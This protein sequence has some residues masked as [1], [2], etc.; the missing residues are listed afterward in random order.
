MSDRSYAWKLQSLRVILPMIFA[1]LTLIFQGLLI[2]YWTG[3]A[4][5]RIKYEAE[6]VAKAMA[7]FQSYT[8]ADVLTPRE[9]HVAFNN[10][11]K[12]MD[13]A[14]LP[15]NPA[16]GKPFIEGI[17]LD[18]DPE[19]VGG[20][21]VDRIFMSRGNTACEA[22]YVT[23]IPLYAEDDRELLGIATF[24][25]S[26]SF[27]RNLR[28]DMIR[29]FV[30]MAVIMLVLIAGVWLLTLLLIRPLGVMADHLRR[31][32]TGDLTPVPPLR[33][34]V[35]SEVRMVK[36]ALEGLLLKARDYTSRIDTAYRE[37]KSAQ[38]QLVQTSRLA[39]IGELAAGVA[40]ELNQP[41]MVIRA[42]AQ[43]LLKRMGRL[44][45]DDIAENLATV[46]RNTGRMVTI[47]NHLR[48]F[49]RQSAAAG[50]VD[51]NRVIDDALSMIGEQLRGRNIAVRRSLLDGLPECHGNQH[52]LE[53]VVLNL[54]TNARD[55]I[56]AKFDGDP[57]GDRPAAEGRIELTTRLSTLRK[58]HVE[59][60]VSD[61][62]A[63]IP[64]EVA[65][66]IF[67]PFFT[68]KAVGKGTGLGLSISFGIIRAHGGEIAVETSDE[69]G[70]VFR[71]VLPLGASPTANDPSG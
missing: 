65:D 61:N 48:D 42:T 69:D 5:P 35:T 7:Q 18:V 41:L 68:T 70:T 58:D 11:T 24:H 37:L 51:L 50:P 71:I 54:L 36:G 67:D 40:H 6:T 4:A 34:L 17:S 8:I 1:G 45:P 20:I 16:T 43:L 3:V 23:E 66:R 31:K 39:S 29:R 53:Q 62:G 30:L 25:M 22:C 10:V 14:I 9:G 59:I 15:T 46:E 26:M 57:Y 60:L 47:I 56:A 44:S 49:S 12:A 52:Q 32:E 55:A 38:A 27:F 2:V 19:A 21:D 64:P 28:D 13:I 63:G 33:G